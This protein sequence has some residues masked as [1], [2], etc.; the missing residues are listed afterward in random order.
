MNKSDEMIG[1]F[2]ENVENTLKEN[3]NMHK[4]LFLDASS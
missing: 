4:N 3:I 2:H 1:G